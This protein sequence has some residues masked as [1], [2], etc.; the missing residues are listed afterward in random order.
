[1][2]DFGDFD[3]EDA[4]DDSDPIEEKLRL[5]SKI[6]V[7]IRDAESNQERKQVRI[8]NVRRLLEKVRTRVLEI[9]VDLDQ[10]SEAVGGL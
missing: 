4:W 1:M 6:L 2:V 10:I 7:S 3:P 9:D 8:Q 5:L